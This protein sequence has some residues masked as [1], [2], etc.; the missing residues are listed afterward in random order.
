MLR[1]IKWGE[2]D[3]EESEDDDD[4][5]EDDAVK[6]KSDCQLVWEGVPDDNTLGFAKGYIPLGAQ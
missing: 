5:D 3:E 2:D 6:H 1:R 4:D